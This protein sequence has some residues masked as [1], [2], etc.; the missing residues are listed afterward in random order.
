MCDLARKTIFY[1]LIQVICLIV[2]LLSLRVRDILY[3]KNY[4][5]FAKSID[6]LTS[7]LYYFI[8][9]KVGAVGVLCPQARKGGFATLAYEAQIR[10]DKTN[11]RIQRMTAVFFAASDEKNK[12]CSSSASVC[13]VRLE[14][15]STSPVL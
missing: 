12:F 3:I 9:H 4:I 1:R 10:S 13:F 6:Y 7:I 8:D 11:V 5:F 15:V 14:K 2:F